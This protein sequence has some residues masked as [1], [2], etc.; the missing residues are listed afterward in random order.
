MPAVKSRCQVGLVV[1]R[2]L[3]LFAWIDHNRHPAKDFEAT[4]D[5]CSPPRIA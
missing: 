2:R 1:V 3:R 5:L 4:E